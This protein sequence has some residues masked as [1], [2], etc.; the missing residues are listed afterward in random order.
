MEPAN[1]HMIIVSV[2]GTGVATILVLWQMIR[3]LRTEMKSEF[4]SVHAELGSVQEEIEIVRNE[5]DTLSFQV[6]TA[7]ESVHKEPEN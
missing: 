6:E 1:F 2:I 4:Q 7:L 5:L 3:S